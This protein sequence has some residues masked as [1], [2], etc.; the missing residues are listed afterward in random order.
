MLSL[1]LGFLSQG[2]SGMSLLWLDCGSI[3]RVA[4]PKDWQQSDVA[5]AVAVCPKARIK[6]KSKWVVAA[7]A[8]PPWAQLHIGS[9]LVWWCGKAACRKPLLSPPGASQ[10][11]LI[12]HLSHVC[13]QSAVGLVWSAG[14]GK[15]AMRPWVPAEP[16]SHLWQGNQMGKKSLTS[17]VPLQGARKHAEPACTQ[18]MDSNRKFVSFCS[19]HL[20]A[21]PPM[22]EEGRGAKY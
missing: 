21:H 3:A 12:L 18:T 11:T 1:L 17:R 15:L 19:F 5:V 6:G 13:V 16:W 10:S 7:G 8:A 2:W 20:P 14:P 4:L 9:C 22:K